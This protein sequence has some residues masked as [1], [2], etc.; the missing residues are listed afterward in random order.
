[1]EIHNHNLNIHYSLPDEI[2]NEISNLYSQMP[3][4]INYID[5]IPYWFGT[6]ETEKF[7]CA[8][9]EPSGLQFYAKMLNEE[10]ESWFNLFKEK[11]T[12]LLGFEVGEPE[13]G[14]KFIF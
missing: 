3:G 14:F 7:I 8:S 4:W 9:V 2:W 6:E 11:A 10:W 5:G 13:D 1:M 12:D